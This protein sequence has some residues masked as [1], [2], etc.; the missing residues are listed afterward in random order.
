MIYPVTQY[1]LLTLPVKKGQIYFVT[2][3]NCLFKDYGNTKSE[4]SRFNAIV[5]NS[6]YNRLNK[7]RPVNGRY[8]Y[9][10]DDNSLWVYDTRWILEDG[11]TSTYNAYGYDSSNAMSPVINTDNTITGPNGDKIID[12]NGLLS[13]G[14]VVIR[15]R[16]RV[17]RGKISRDLIKQQINFTNYLDNGITFYPYGMGK[18]DFER[19]EVGSLTLGINT[20]LEGESVNG[21]L[22]RKG[23]ADYYGDFYIH[24]DVYTVV[25]RSVGEY[26]L[27]YVPEISEQMTHY[28]KT[29]V[30]NTVNDLKEIVYSEVEISVISKN[31]ASV[32]IIKYRDGL[33]NAV[34]GKDGKALYNSAITLISDIIYDAKRTII[35]DTVVSYTLIGPSVENTFT[36]DGTAY[37]SKVTISNKPEYSDEADIT[38]KTNL[39]QRIKLTSPASLGISSSEIATWSL[40]PVI[41]GVSGKFSINVTFPISVDTYQVYAKNKPISERL[42]VTDKFTTAPMIFDGNDVK[43]ALYNKGNLIITTSCK[44]SYD[45]NNV[46]T[47]VLYV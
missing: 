32:R 42:K 2:D 40:E 31:T 7:I 37:S 10:S 16:N 44:K 3:L 35:S 39:K 36:L 6:Q 38:A 41:S 26:D 43:I 29:S 46:K 13:D 27:S 21:T 20:S 5:I 23:V 19:R 30:T 11:D 18:N 25:E 47:G 8:Y 34:I 9:V 15:D 1:D 33:D 17:I 14:S 22:T 28:F 12:N 45:I 4:R 24:G